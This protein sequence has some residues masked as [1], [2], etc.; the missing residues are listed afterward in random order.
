MKAPS[1]IFVVACLFFMVA[2][3]AHAE[4]KKEDVPELLKALKSGNAK[5]RI[6]AADDLGHIGAIRAED[7]KE[8][9]PVLLD[10]LKNDRAAGVRKAVATALGRMDPDP[11]EAVPVLSKALKD[12]DAGVRA[13]AATSLGQL[14]ADAKDAVPALNEA[15]KDKDRNVSRAAGMA[16]RS[17]QGKKK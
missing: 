9:V 15:R 11:Q 8:A 10:M 16:L 2:T 12:K 5:K 17:I 3:A 4:P 6:S 13:A 7:A 14:G 1:M